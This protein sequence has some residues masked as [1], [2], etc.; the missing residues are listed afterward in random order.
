MPPPL[1][2]EPLPEIELAPPVAP[3]EPLFTAAPTPKPA[4]SLEFSPAEPSPSIS[5]PVV[6]ESPEQPSPDA[7]GELE[8][9]PDPDDA[10]AYGEPG[11]AAMLNELDANL[12]EGHE[13]FLDE[14]EDN[15]DLPPGMLAAMVQSEVEP[16]VAVE[17]PE[18]E[19]GDSLTA[20]DREQ[21]PL[22]DGETEDEDQEPHTALFADDY[23]ADEGEGEGEDME[24]GSDEGESAM[25]GSGKRALLSSPDEGDEDDLPPIDLDK[26]PKGDTPEELAA[27][28]KLL[29][30]SFRDS[31][32]AEVGVDPDMAKTAKEL[33]ISFREDAD[34]SD[35]VLDEMALEAQR[36]GISFRE[37]GGPSTGGLQKPMI[38]RYLPL[39]LGVV[40]I[41]FLLLLG[42]TFAQDIIV[43]FWS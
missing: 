30:I 17:R 1:V 28:A 29:G 3:A 38:V 25:S 5:D 23:G 13:P 27:A 8:D 12:D 9:L 42:A 43:W 22:S 16:A 37:D 33:G 14:D 15:V 4:P 35:A 21:Q 18:A 20:M 41:F 31:D 7:A 40:A 24:P 32:P 36:L 39:F 11:P 26:L 10:E 34:E 6:A 19:P 2:F